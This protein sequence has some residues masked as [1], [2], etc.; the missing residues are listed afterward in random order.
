M[1]I[2]EPTY[3]SQFNISIMPQW[4]QD[5]EDQRVKVGNSLLYQMGDNINQFGE[6]T[7]VSIE[8][9]SVKA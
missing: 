3:E 6:K 5:L 7:R 1:E 8:L 4:L 2:V 9:E